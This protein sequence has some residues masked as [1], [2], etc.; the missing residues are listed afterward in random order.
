MGQ[1]ARF[2]GWMERKDGAELAIPEFCLDD[3]VGYVY[4]CMADH[5]EARVHAGDLRSGQQLPAER[6]LA[7]EYRVSLGTTRRATQELR[8][9]GVIVTVP[10][11]GSYVRSVN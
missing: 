3:Y 5:L 8:R 7:S 2:F 9:R 4:V 1:S 11:K 10:V 6:D